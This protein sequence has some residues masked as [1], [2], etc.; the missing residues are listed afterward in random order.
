MTE[1]INPYQFF[2][3]T[4]QTPFGEFA[5]LD[6]LPPER[7]RSRHASYAGWTG[8]LTVTF[9]A[10]SPV[11][12]LEPSSAQ[13]VRGT[14]DHRSYGIVRDRNGDAYIP[15]TSIKGAVRSFGEASSQSRFGVFGRN[16]QRLGYRPETSQVDATPAEIVSIDVEHNKVL[17]REHLGLSDENP[18]AWFPVTFE[19]GGRNV[20]ASEALGTDASNNC[21]RETVAGLLRRLGGGVIWG[22]YRPAPIRLRFVR[23]VEVRHA[24]AGQI[25]RVD[26]RDQDPA[27]TA[28][29]E[30]C[31]EKSGVYLKVGYRV[32]GDYQTTGDSTTADDGVLLVGGLPREGVRKHDER[33]AFWPASKTTSIGLDKLDEL[34]IVL[35]DSALAK[36]AIALGDL[37][38]DDV[39]AYLC[40]RFR[41]VSAP[42]QPHS[43]LAAFEALLP[44]AGS[45]LFV[46]RI[47]GNVSHVG[48]TLVTRRV[49]PTAPANF[50]PSQFKKASRAGEWSLT[51]RLFGWAP[52]EDGLD[53]PLRGRIRFG[54]GIV[55]AEDQK[56]TRLPSPVPL[57]ILSSP[58]VQQSRFYLG[59]WGTDHVEPLEAQQSRGQGG[60]VQTTN[61]RRSLRGWKVFPNQRGLPPDHWTPMNDYRAWLNRAPSSQLDDQSR[62][63]REWIPPKANVTC[64]IDVEN[65][66]HGELAVLLYALGVRGDGTLRPEWHLRLGYGKPLGFGSLKV[67]SVKPSLWTA[68]GIAGSLASWTPENIG[69]APVAEVDS[70]ATV[71]GTVMEHFPISKAVRV[72]ALRTAVGV[73]D[74]NAR[75]EYPWI[76]P[77]VATRQ[78]RGEEGRAAALRTRRAIEQPID[79]IPPKSGLAYEWFGENSAQ[80]GGRIA[81]LSLPDFADSNATIALPADP[82][83]RA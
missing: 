22:T 48:P 25:W 32:H 55:S 11:A 20:A 29:C 76:S 82:W 26:Y 9:E 10:A 47:E 46:H 74:E 6:K 54:D 21:C 69:I 49:H 83:E 33:L 28:E 12:V 52:D 30:D 70:I 34:I 2:P 31:G 27:W 50:L 13:P 80:R 5:D 77:D 62:S 51:D 71:A 15:T 60:Y 81:G 43:K 38:R 40:S 58:K 42:A 8:T 59:R 16:D 57:A 56:R 73:G 1:F 41:D 63:L 39:V 61:E 67:T 7:R 19:Q 53:Q 36:K 68:G 18:A 24:R 4:K 45:W 3:F 66:T 72:S 35:L 44:C 14:K 37:D 17:V 23:L 75:V 79:S 65:L 78:I 64:K